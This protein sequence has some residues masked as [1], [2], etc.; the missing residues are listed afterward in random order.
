MSKDTKPK[1]QIYLHSMLDNQTIM[2]LMLK[3]HIIS[4]IDEETGD[5]IMTDG[6]KYNSMAE[7]DLILQFETDHVLRLVNCDINT[8]PVF[9]GTKKFETKC[10]HCGEEDENMYSCKYRYTLNQQGKEL[11][12]VT[13]DKFCKIC[14]RYMRGI[15]GRCGFCALRFMKTKRI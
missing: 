2:N 10:P 7:E 12:D 5:I 6:K 1:Y 14:K 11:D 4:K 8:I 3:K 15:K 9:G 13:S